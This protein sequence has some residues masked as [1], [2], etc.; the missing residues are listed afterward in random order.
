MVQS[1]KK[2]KISYSFQKILTGSDLSSRRLAIME[3]ESRNPGPVVWLTAAIHGDEV[4][5][6]AVV[7]EVFKQL[8]KYPLLKGTIKAMPL[9]NPIGFESGTRRIRSEER[10]VGKE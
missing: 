3:I 1:Y 6:I 10:R 2:Q 7:Q 5:G 9:M 8:R 4:G